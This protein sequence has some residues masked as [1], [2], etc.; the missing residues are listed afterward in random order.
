[1]K[2]IFP[3]TLLSALIIFI[4]LLIKP[5]T[6]F[7][8]ESYTS[9]L[10]ENNVTITSLNFY[11]TNVSLHIGN[12]NNTLNIQVL[13]FSPLLLDTQYIGD[14]DA[15]K[16]YHPLQGIAKI[17]A[18]ISYNNHLKITAKMDLKDT[19]TNFTLKDTDFTVK[20]SLV[21]PYLEKSIISANGSFSNTLHVEASIKYK[22]DEIRLKDINYKD[23]VLSLYTNYFGQNLYIKMLDNRINYTSKELD[24]QN[25]LKALHKENLATGFIDVDGVFNL[26]EKKNHVDVNS[27]KIITNGLS[28]KALH[29]EAV[30]DIEKTTFNLD[31][32]LKNKPLELKGEL[33]YA[34]DLE[35]KLFTQN[36]DSN[37]SFY[38]ADKKFKFIS[39][40][41]N[42]QRVQ[43][44]FD[45]EEKVFGDIDL[46]ASGTLDDIVFKVYS[47]KVNIPEISTYLKPFLLSMSGRYHDNKISFAPY[48][49][50]KN[51]ILSRGKNVYNIKTKKLKLNQQLILR[52]KKKLVPIYMQANLKLS[53]PYEA[54]VHIGKENSISNININLNKTY[55]FIKFEKLKLVNIDNFIDKNRLFDKGQL[56]G[57]ITYNLQTKSATS[58]VVVYDAILNGIDLDRALNNLKDALGLNVVNLGRNMINN[59]KNSIQK[60]YIKQLQLNAYLDHGLITLE[61]VALATKK[62]R[63]SAFGDIKKDGTIKQLNVDILDKNGCSLI[64]QELVGNIK[65]PKPKSTSTAIVGVASAIPSALLSTGKK[66]INFGAK[67]VDGVASY[68]LEKSHISSNDVS[69]TSDL[70]NTSGSMLKSTSDIVLPSECKVIYNGK[71]KHPI[72]KTQ[73]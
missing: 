26:R 45:L 64:T 12:E 60:T 41:L 73:K 6:I 17:N 71:V 8:A 37:S 46:E 20:T 50:N 29:V 11:D 42:L 55:L 43:V 16:K 57:D 58:N 62:F 18:N 63:I 32:A 7:L 31:L 54:K 56:N 19:F 1:M 15:F 14:V 70:V 61:D 9:L 28:I 30:S 51:Y 53:K 49:K 27:Y 36:F 3:W 39:K 33:T 72:Q 52:E 22:N 59:Y 25:I 47:N 48:I 13:N 35:L 24:I 5:A 65:E 69:L 38:F 10:L 40:H 66:L 23:D 4:T 21:L 2:A 68:A 44:G 67:S 34:D